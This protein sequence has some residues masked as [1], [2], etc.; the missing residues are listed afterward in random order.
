MPSLSS[1]NLALASHQ[2]GQLDQAE[3]FYHKVLAIQ[4]QHADSLHNLG[5][6]WLERG[7]PAQALP[8]LKQALALQPEQGLFW[9]S[10]LEALIY[11]EQYT[12][13]STLLKEGVAQGLEGDAVTQLAASLTMAATLPTQDQRLTQGF[14]QGDD[15]T[16]ESLARKVTQAC[17]GHGFAW[18]A[19]GVALIRQQQPELALAALQH[20]ANRLPND[21]AVYANLANALTSLARHHEAEQACRQALALKPD[22]LQ[23]YNNLGNALKGQMRL[24][25]A[26]ISYRQAMRDPAHDVEA[27]N[28]LAV[29]LQDQGRLE[30]AEVCL[31]RV[32]AKAPNFVV[33]HN[34]L[35]N[36][37]D[38]RGKPEAAIAAYRQAL[39]LDP[40]YAQ[41]HNNL[42]CSLKQQGLFTEAEYAFTQALR[43]HPNDYET[44]NNLGD[45]LKDMGRLDEASQ[46][47]WHSWQMNPSYPTA[48]DNLLLLSQYAENIS[49]EERQAFTR[50]Y[51][52]QFET[53]LPVPQ[54][55]HNTPEPSRR[56]RLGWVSADL[57]NHSVAYFTLPVFQGLSS[58][59]DH[60]VYSNSYQQDVISEQ[61]QACCVSWRQV[62]SMSDDMLAAQIRADQVDILI[63]LSGHTASNRLPVF[64]RQPAPVQLTWLGY[65]DTTGLQHMGWR[66]TDTQA[67][68][69]H[70]DTDYTERLWRLPEVFCCYRPMV[71]A[72]EQRSAPRYAVQ[73]T[74][75]LLRGQV[76]FGCCNNV[77]KLTPT[78]IAL[79]SQILCAQPNSRLLLEL[80]GI[81]HQSVRAAL[82]A[83]FAMH[84]VEPNRLE[85][86]ERDSRQQYL[87]YHLIDIVLDPFPAN[88]GAS[89]CDALWMGTPL[90]TLAGSRFVS[91]MGS[92]LL[93]AIGHPEWVATN[94]ADYVRLALDLASDLPRLNTWRLGLR[95]EVEASP[96]MDEARFCQHFAQALRGM[97]QDWCETASS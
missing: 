61:H 93:Q 12:Q 29:V 91:R 57:R 30:E 82:L 15:A 69:P 50:A 32:L 16:V 58:E 6:L 8:W 79:W 4:P 95:A 66:I 85:L 10:C 71:R 36:V 67:D 86:V 11:D 39:A 68:L 25:E 1:F 42:G 84:G 24:E 44:S 9:I 94:E 21:P 81:Q 59:M 60:L 54:P 27:G 19:L 14:Q 41:A 64:A 33:A 56:L 48:L 31:R 62:A 43:L 97:W 53:G 52:Q 63:D 55:W 17:P 18:K 7:Q 74:P 90:L 26:E 23:A 92:S 76:T 73:P 49:Q 40:L 38:E 88:G 96:L 35:G 46:A 83:Q 77:A 80:A 70:S 28:N 20:A 72:P 34:N 51:A 2:A 89:S 87:S 78:V 45:L 3:I 5:A 75:A 65:P 22:Y 37:L 47:F 13:A